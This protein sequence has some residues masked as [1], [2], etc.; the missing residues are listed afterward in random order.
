[1]NSKFLAILPSFGEIKSINT[2]ITGRFSPT[3]GVQPN[4]PAGGGIPPRQPASMATTSFLRPVL[5]GG[6]DG[7]THRPQAWATQER[8]SLRR[9]FP[10]AGKAVKP[11]EGRELADSLRRRRRVFRRT[12]PIVERVSGRAGCVHGPSDAIKPWKSRLERHWTG[13]RGKA[14]TGQRSSK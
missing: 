12:A 9:K 6:S 7:R 8:R 14:E 5:A 1:M 2:G 11:R 10:E 13:S 3:A 4:Q